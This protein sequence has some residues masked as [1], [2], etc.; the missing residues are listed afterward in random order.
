MNRPDQPEAPCGCYVTVER[1]LRAVGGRWWLV[2]PALLFALTGIAIC[3][4]MR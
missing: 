3:I 2:V 4:G 1:D